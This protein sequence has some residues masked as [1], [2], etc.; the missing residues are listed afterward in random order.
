[1]LYLL[2]IFSFAKLTNAQIGVTACTN[3]TG[4]STL[5][6]SVCDEFNTQK[7]VCSSVQKYQAKT[8]NSGCDYNCGALTS[9]T[10]GAVSTTGTL[11]TS[12]AT[13][14]CSA[15]FM[16]TGVSN[17]TCVLGSGWSGVA[18]TCVAGKVGDSCATVTNLCQ[19]LINAP[20]TG[21]TCTCLLGYTQNSE[22][23]CVE[24]NECGSSP[25]KFGA[26]CINEIAKYTCTCA[27]GYNGTQC[28]INPNDC[29]SDPCRN[30]GSCT[31]GLATFT[32][33]CAAGFT[34]ATCATN[35]NEC[36]ST[37]CQNGGTCNDAVNGYTCSCVAGFT[38]I[39][40]ETNI[41]ECISAPCKNGASC[42]DAVNK[43]T[44]TCA[45]GFTGTHCDTNIDDCASNPCRNGGNCAD[46]IARYTCTCA[47]GY[48]GTN[49]D[50]NI[51]ECASTPCKNGA[52]C[53][54]KVNGYT[55][56]CVAGYTSTLCETEINECSSSPC[57][58]GATCNDLV[59][60]YTCGCAPGYTGPTCASDINECASTPCQHFGT[61]HDRV[62]GFNCTCV[63]GYNGH[64][65][66][67]NIDEC[68]AATCLNGGSC[69]D[70]INK[71]TCSC[72][73]GYT[74]T[75]CETNINECA[76]AICQNG[77]SCV[78]QVN[79]YICNCVSGYTGTHCET[80]INECTGH[81]CENGATCLDGIAKY[82][83]ECAPGYNGTLCQ[84][85]I[86]ECAG[87]TCQNGAT[88]VDIVN[89]FT[90]TC[91]NGFTG[92]FCQS[93]I[94]DCSPNPCQN[95]GAC[96]DLVYAY[97]C[98]CLNGYTGSTCATDINDCS[99][100]PCVNGICTD[101]VF[102]YTCACSSGYSGKNCSTDVNECLSSPCRNGGT[103][104]DIVNG[105]FCRCAAGY[106]GVT[107]QTDANECLSSLC[108][109]GSTCVDRVNG[110]ICQCAPGY[111]GQYCDQDINECLSHQCQNS[112][113]CVD[114]VNTY[115]CTCKA[116]YT[117]TLCE[118]DINDCSPNPCQNGGTCTD[119]VNGYTCACADGYTGTT[120][121]PATLNNDCSGRPGVCSN[122]LKAEC[123]GLK[124]VCTSGYYQMGSV[125]CS[126]KDCGTIVPAIYG[127]VNHSEGTFYEAKAYFSCETGYARTGLASVS[128]RA[129]QTWSGST[130]ICVIKDC[131]TLSK[132]LNGSV[133]FVPN[134][135]YLSQAEFE[136]DIGYSLS[137]NKTRTCTDTGRATGVWAGTSPTCVIKDCGLLTA[138]GNGTIDTQTGTKYQSVTLFYCNTGFDLI[139][140]SSTKCGADGV[141]DSVKPR[142]Q[143]KDCLSLA[144]P[145]NGNINLP[146]GTTYSA[147]VT[148]T[149]NIG[150]TLN[151]IASRICQSTG[152]WTN[153]PPTCE[154]N[155]CSVLSN[156]SNGK[157][158]LSN[159]T[160]YQSTAVYTCNS[161]FLLSGSASR[162]CQ[163][164]KT[165]SSSEPI[166]NRISCPTLTAP[167]NGAVDLSDGL[168]YEDIATFSC[169][170]GYAMVGTSTRQCLATK[171]W[172]GE[173]PTC[174][175]KNCGSLTYPDNG[176]VLTVH[177]TE[178][179]K[180]ANYSCNQGYIISGVSTRTCLSSG[181]WSASPPTCVILDCGPVANIT[182][183]TLTYSPANS[184]QYGST[185]F[186]DCNDG[187]E[188]KEVSS[189]VCEANGLWSGTQPSCAILSCDEPSDIPNGYSWLPSGNQVGDYAMYA[190]NSG[191]GLVGDPS[192]ICKPSGHWD[193]APECRLDCGNPPSVANG[194]VT[195]PDGTLVGKN[196]TYSCYNGY[197]VAGK[198]TIVCTTSGV[199]AESPRCNLIQIVYN[200]LC[201]VTAQCK[202]KGST[203]RDDTNGQ[204]RCLC[205][206]TRQFFDS[207]Q[208]KCLS[209][210]EPLPN[211]TNGI[212]TNPS[213]LAES[214]KAT[215]T[216]FVGYALNG[217]GT[218]YCLS[219]GQWDT[220]AP[221]CITGC[222]VP[223]APSH[224]YVNASD[225][226]AAGDIIR[227]SCDEGYALLGVQE[228]ICGWD[229]KW[230]G[231]VPSCVIEC[232]LLDSIPNGY[233]DMSLGNWVG[234]KAT[235]IC[236]NNHALVGI[237]TRTC[238]STGVWS[239]V[240]PT[241]V[242]AIFPDVIL[243]FGTLFVVLV[244]VDIF[245]ISV[246]LY[247]RYCKTKPKP[248][249]VE[250][251]KEV[252]DVFDD[253]EDPKELTFDTFKIGPSFQRSRATVPEQPN[254]VIK[255]KD[256]PFRTAVSTT[257]I[258]LPVTNTSKAKGSDN[259][260][261]ER[262]SVI[263][264]RKS[265]D[266]NPN[267]LSNRVVAPMPS[268]VRLP[269]LHKML[270][271]VGK[272]FNTMS[273]DDSG[274]EKSVTEGRDGG[275]HTANSDDNHTH[276][277]E[278][279]EDEFGD[280]NGISP[281]ISGDVNP[282]PIEKRRNVLE[283][284]ADTFRG[285]AVIPPVMDSPH[286]EKE[287]AAFKPETRRQL[288]GT[289]ETYNPP[290]MF[291]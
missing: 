272:E 28:E 68:A 265:N 21:G 274:H 17:R 264:G 271:K 152:Q 175:I 194:L 161:G 280:P 234:S 33:S 168:L 225:G 235:Y 39:H 233:V 278:S 27:T 165:W 155:T 120:C 109:T 211:P 101:K 226:L 107:C 256:T 253:Y 160:K 93:N 269:P 70:G 287:R 128:C 151:G 61:C 71:F 13:Y 66:Q 132:P 18:P 40:C 42:F 98:T 177:G 135:E 187:Y 99:P 215:Y 12:V 123:D 122:I 29:A 77:G 199:W 81:K 184:K 291:Q 180:I 259:V 198:D 188:I 284:A 45:T 143:I 205:A 246:C 204:D 268:K 110:Y 281:S 55:C 134:T 46:G 131:G 149:C 276:S 76:T 224:G 216:C 178:Y 116:G 137:G 14:T 126:K 19:N 238:E 275:Y 147:N 15:G 117:G 174:Q 173:S 86:N 153:S 141:W 162:T 80:N 186:Y 127:N 95:G 158:D 16:L 176:L 156:P 97:K 3:I 237:S 30:G 203:C 78:D 262:N 102:D 171:L 24:I 255:E 247:Y 11:Q 267:D 242:F 73:P 100:D 249:P 8:D 138:P 290:N 124:C 104:T 108:R 113:T 48:T 166:C 103:C 22:T 41:N 218:R 47:A 38:G 2:F 5:P 92:V 257:K 136:C 148:Y 213:V 59:N 31:D 258:L 190:C 85:N 121:S 217:P 105:Y 283:A 157:V 34:G 220:T 179:L 229:S 67:N 170:T 196:A 167:S 56:T 185:V 114:K 112:A 193:S 286:T 7:C 75:T 90:C 277:F 210:C 243:V 20:C 89:G 96:A 244:L 50:T 118:I 241:C 60:L 36:A 115:T 251:K 69:N 222:P 58:N 228:R 282:S 142:C 181:I 94:N 289:V 139:G 125:T 26:T 248:L 223:L 169:N 279:S 6:N 260:A 201:S 182:Q 250:P 44:C 25:C 254:P 245:V 227:Y 183:G 83:C 35:I 82:T 9:P 195:V 240:V 154:I 140:V 4:C 263:K 51:D 172:S 72:K 79:S 65:C 150:Y 288:R 10:N 64:V 23:E 230:S 146:Q 285:R 133:S 32:C 270:T 221:L 130:P 53:T 62:N 91:V 252:P 145:A 200:T 214:Q 74:G 119:K 63:S 239:G 189:R 209:I 219:T 231:S 106:E 164:D 84:N 206:L 232:P 261:H 163:A 57:K 144:A 212:V 197:E 111:T 236:T 54:D 159:G 273:F 192:V 266:L 202:T 207:S 191:Y 208:D 88:C 52:A 43:Y 1:M 37:P 129:D 49:C 87:H